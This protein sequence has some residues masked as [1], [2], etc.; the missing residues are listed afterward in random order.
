VLIASLAAWGFVG[1][2]NRV[3]EGKSDAFDRSV[4]LLLRSPE[5]STDLLGPPWMEEMA[6]DVTALGSLVVLTGLTVVSAAFLLLTRRR[7]IAAFL[8]ATT[9]V[10]AIVS[11][12]LKIGFDRDR[13]DLVPHATRAFSKSFPS[14][15]SAMSALVFLTLGALLCRIHHS[16]GVQTYFLGVACGVTLL[17]GVSRV[18][19]GVHWPT[20]V[21]AGWAFGIAW[22]A[23]S[24]LVFDAIRKPNS[25]EST[26]S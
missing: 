25:V 1:V 18:Y 23:T 8:I 4:L 14:G 15:H 16:R 5:N 2:A 20:D 6:R 7:A 13:P 22:A 26:V 24:S 11:A 12:L 21:V 10:G 17:V 9:S 19:L 3:F